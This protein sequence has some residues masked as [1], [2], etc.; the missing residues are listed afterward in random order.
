MIL[1]KLSI[2]MICVSFS[3]MMLLVRS[4]L[5]HNLRH[6]SMGKSGFPAIEIPERSRFLVVRLFKWRGID[7]EERRRNPFGA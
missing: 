1:I 6:I 5:R 3:A 2:E 7:Q 4:G